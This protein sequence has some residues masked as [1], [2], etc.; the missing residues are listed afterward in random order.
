MKLGL[1]S[2]TVEGSFRGRTPSFGDLQQMAVVSEQIGLDSFWLADHLLYRFGDQDE[3]GSWEALTLLSGLAAVTSRISLGPIV[4]C[5]AFRNPALLAK[6]ADTIDEI[7]GGRFIL[8]LGAG[9]HEPEF[10]AFGYP[11]DHRASRFE[12]ALKIIAPLLHNGHVDFH[13]QYYE[14]NNCVLRPRGPSNGGP[15]IWIGARQPRMLRLVAQ[16]ADAWN[17]VWHLSAAKVAEAYTGFKKACVE[18]GRG[19][20]TIELTAGT[21]VN[22]LRPGEEKWLDEGISGSSQQIADRLAEFANVGVQHL[23][24]MIDPPDLLGLERLARVIELMP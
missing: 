10:E 12:E 3:R 8:G 1:A 19:I 20:G 13:G 21:M 17:T 9:W 24:V 23:L 6:M 22:L 4:A 14:A 5:T 11:F 16:Y 15:P 18:V 7:S 2:G